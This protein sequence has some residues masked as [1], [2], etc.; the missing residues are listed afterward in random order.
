MIWKQTFDFSINNG[1]FIPMHPQGHPDID[2]AIYSAGGWNSV[3]NTFGIGHS[4]VRI[5]SILVFP[6]RFT[7]VKLVYSATDAPSDLYSFNFGVNLA[8]SAVG[9]NLV[10][11]AD[12]DITTDNLRTDLFLGTAFATY[13][14]KSLEFTGT[15]PNPFIPQ[16]D[17]R[18]ESDCSVEAHT[19]DEGI[20]G[21]S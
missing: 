6:A 17:N 10:T 5:G 3:Y 7:H 2:L 12:C 20:P 16:S 8:S 18:G 11:E 21:S 1:G 15:G 19:G 9:S 4:E 13:T 14:I